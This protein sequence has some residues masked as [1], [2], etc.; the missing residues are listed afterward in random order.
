MSGARTERP[1]PRRQREARRRGEVARS[2]ELLALAALAGGLAAICAT[3]RG[4]LSALSR[5]LRSG[6][7]RSLDLAPDPAAALLAALGAFARAAAPVLA[8]AALAAGLA[9]RLV[10]GPVFS[11]EACAFRLD[12]LGPRRGLSRLCSGA[13]LGRAPLEALRAAVLVASGGLALRAAA[14]ALSRLPRLEPRAL[15]AGEGLLGA[16]AVAALLPALALFAAADLGLALRRHRAAL[17]MTREEV[18]RDQREEEGD[19]QR[20]A[21]RRRLHRALADAPPLSRATC[22]VVNPV[23]F[24]VALRHER[25][26]DEAPR[27]LAKGAGEAAARLRGAARRAGVP[28]VEDVPLARALHRLCEVGEEIPEELFEAAA[29]VLAHLYAGAGRAVEGE[30]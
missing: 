22:L 9:G 4:L 21:E 13:R 20:R 29:A 12:R 23:H 2:P 24:A 14:P 18:R 8:G 5:L 25:G 11:F 27:V 19:P 7:E 16:R 1:T 6:L 3:G 28:V 17:R 10:A 26:S 30:A 15:L